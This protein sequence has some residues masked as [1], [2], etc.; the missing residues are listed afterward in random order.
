MSFFLGSRYH[1]PRPLARFS[2]QSMMAGPA[3]SFEHF[4]AIKSIK[5]VP[6]ERGT[7]SN[8]GLGASGYTLFSFI[9]RSFFRFR[10]SRGYILFTILTIWFPCDLSVDRRLDV[11]FV[12][13]G[14]VGKIWVMMDWELFG[15]TG[16]G[17]CLRTSQWS[18]LAC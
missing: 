4:L 9:I 6:K 14:L 15:Y 16:L 11:S 17:V 5:K 8:A 10:L 13:D 18:M 7:R 3:G 12:L 2:F 1:N